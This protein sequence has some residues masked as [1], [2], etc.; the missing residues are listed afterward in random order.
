MNN[1]IFM[2]IGDSLIS[3]KEY[4]INS[5]VITLSDDIDRG[6]KKLDQDDFIFT[7]I[8]KRLNITLGRF[9]GKNLMVL[10]NRI[11]TYLLDEN[12]LIEDGSFPVTFQKYGDALLLH[13]AEKFDIDLSL[14]WMVGDV[15]DEIEAGNSAGCRTVLID[16]GHEREWKLNEN[17]IPDLV[18]KNVEEAA[19]LILVADEILLPKGIGKVLEMRSENKL[20]WKWFN[21][22]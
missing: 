14:S 22:N 5:D 18:A 20:A 1:A 17:R 9:I 16:N 11:Y 19:N 3:Q 2:Y 4:K 12:K 15:L 10:N 8:S 7:F 21:Q 13:A 6:L